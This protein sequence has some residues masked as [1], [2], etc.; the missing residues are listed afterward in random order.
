VVSG[1]D[2]A[3]R[4]L[5]FCL[6]SFSSSPGPGPQ[7]NSGPPQ[8]GKV[9]CSGHR[10][11]VQVTG[12]EFRSKV[13]SSGQRVKSSEIGSFTVYRDLQCIQ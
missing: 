3:R 6:I 13:Q 8:E 5:D 7:R 4:H 2:R 1:D 12:S 9:K 10:V 11:R